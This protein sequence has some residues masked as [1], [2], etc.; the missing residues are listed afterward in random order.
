[1]SNEASGEKTFFTRKT[2][3]NELIDDDES[4]R[5][6]FFFQGTNSTD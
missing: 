6:Q 4:T 2:A 5:R 1:M 3:V